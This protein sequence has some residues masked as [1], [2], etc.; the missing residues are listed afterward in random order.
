MATMAIW[1]RQLFMS[2]LTRFFGKCP[3]MGIA[4]YG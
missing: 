2:R 4:L 3:A 1:R